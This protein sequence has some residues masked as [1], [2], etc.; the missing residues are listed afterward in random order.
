M[1]KQ[2]TLVGVLPPWSADGVYLAVMNSITRG[3]G[4][5]GEQVAKKQQEPVWHTQGM[6][7]SPPSQ[8]ATPTPQAPALNSM[9]RALDMVLSLLVALDSDAS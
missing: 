9:P 6:T 1:M 2:Y 7:D 3:A 8:A 4:E 5:Q